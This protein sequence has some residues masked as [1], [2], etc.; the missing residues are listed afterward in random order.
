MKTL[1]LSILC[2][3][4]LPALAQTAFTT[5]DFV[6]SWR[7]E[8]YDDETQTSSLTE[9]WF[10]ES[11]TFYSQSLVDDGTTT[12]YYD[13]G[14]TWTYEDGKVRLDYKDWSDSAADTQFLQFENFS[15]VYLSFRRVSE[16]GEVDAA[17]YEA[18]RFETSSF[19]E[20]C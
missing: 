4:S 5:D 10:G 14:G 7:I 12:R 6:G 19:H 15:G 9:V 1:F 16:D 3:L 8:H 11:G 20:G 13:S 17:L 18:H 2:C